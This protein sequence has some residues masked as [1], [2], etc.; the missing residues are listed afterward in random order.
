MKIVEKS[1]HIGIITSKDP[2]TLVWVVHRRVA[3]TCSYEHART[4]L[5]TIQVVQF[6]ERL[7]KIVQSSELKKNN[8]Q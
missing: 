1:K 7:R 4:R 8:D 2:L 5:P 6:A 3:S